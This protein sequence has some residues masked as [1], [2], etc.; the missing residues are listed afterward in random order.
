MGVK[1][2]DSRPASA[3]ANRAQRH[4]PMLRSEQDIVADV[5][6]RMSGGL[7]EVSTPPASN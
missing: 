1:Q 7:P 2:P 3:A 5:E 4:A 6:A